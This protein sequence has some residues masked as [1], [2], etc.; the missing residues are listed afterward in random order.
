MYVTK[1]QDLAKN[2]KFMFEKL[3]IGRRARFQAVDIIEWMVPKIVTRIEQLDKIG[4][5]LSG[6]H[7]AHNDRIMFLE[8]VSTFHSETGKGQKY[9]VFHILFKQNFQKNVPVE[10]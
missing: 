3:T 6:L 7:F 9:V 2:R 8:N 5:F 1:N 4:S 10:T